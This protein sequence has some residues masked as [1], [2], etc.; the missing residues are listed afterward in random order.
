M[1]RN[2]I[3]SMQKEILSLNRCIADVSAR[4]KASKVRGRLRI[5]YQRKKPQYFHVTDKTGQNGRYLKKNEF[6]LVRELAQAEYD[7]QLLKLVIKWRDVLQSA[8]ESFPAEYLT[9]IY[10]DAPH[11]RELVEN[12]VVTDVEYVEQWQNA[13]YKKLDYHEQEKRYPSN[14]GEYV[15]SKSEKIIADLLFDWQIPYRYEPEIMI[16]AGRRRKRHPLYPDFVLLDV[17]N[18]QEI[19]LEHF[20]LTSDSGYANQMTR[21]ISDYAAAGYVL[22]KR[23]LMTVESDSESLDIDG[24]KAMLEPL[25]QKGSPP[26]ADSTSEERFA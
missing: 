16:P 13:P 15:R 12:K 22:G 19:V 21:K 1:I 11:R 14:R 26:P 17:V 4:I 8:V 18:R 20:G 3:D 7:A 6:R 2:V 23:F 10:Q 5:S 9:D 25:A 24:L